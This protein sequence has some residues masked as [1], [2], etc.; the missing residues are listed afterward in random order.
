MYQKDVGLKKAL[1][2]AF[3]K[4]QLPTATGGSEE[5]LAINFDKARVS[6]VI[7]KICRGLYYF[8]C[9][10]HLELD[11]TVAV[12]RITTKTQFE[13]FNTDMILGQRGWPGIF[14]FRWNRVKEEPM[15]S[16]WLLLFH[17]SLAWGAITHP[18]GRFKSVG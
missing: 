15:L 1:V 9:G 14:E 6:T 16:K 17:G 3:K 13:Q 4:V 5:R 18:P 10:E 7:E 2:R 12:H 11:L 8:E